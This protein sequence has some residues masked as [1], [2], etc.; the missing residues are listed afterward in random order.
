MGYA[1]M[2][3]FRAGIANPYCFFDLFKNETSILRIH[4]V[5]LMDV[6]LKDYMHLDREQSLEQIKQMIDTVRSVNGE[7]I[8]LWHNES[9]SER[10]GWQGWRKHF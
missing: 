3:G 1:A 8:N 7:F 6:S 10:D 5:V 4:P 2:P 9:L